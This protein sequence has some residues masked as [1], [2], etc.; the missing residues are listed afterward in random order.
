MISRNEYELEDTKEG[1]LQIKR[2]GEG[3]EDVDK[4]NEKTNKDETDE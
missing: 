1:R 2:K 3:K 4:E